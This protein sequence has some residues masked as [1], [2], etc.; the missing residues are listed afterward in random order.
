[1]H[2][3]NGDETTSKQPKKNLRDLQL[4]KPKMA[5]RKRYLKII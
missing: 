4:G 3:F 5:T 2:L 1:M